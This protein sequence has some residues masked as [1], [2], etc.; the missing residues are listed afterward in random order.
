VAASC[1]TSNEWVEF[2]SQSN[3][4]RKLARSVYCILFCKDFLLQQIFAGE[5][6]GLNAKAR[7]HYRGLSYA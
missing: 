1:V 7:F 3:D 5:L 4:F 2:V 6:A